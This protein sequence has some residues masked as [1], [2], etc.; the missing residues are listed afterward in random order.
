M[1]FQL[2][3]LSAC[4]NVLFDVFLRVHN[5]QRKVFEIYVIS[6]WGKVYILCTKIISVLE[7]TIVMYKT[8]HTPYCTL[9][10]ALL[11]LLADCLTNLY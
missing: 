2:L 10:I 8:I 1:I 3:R 5:E 6:K 7:M 11:S 9:T 4:Q